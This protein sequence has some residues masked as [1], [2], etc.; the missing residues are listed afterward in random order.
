MGV[1]V[2][3]LLNRK[4]KGSGA[5]G[6]KSHRTGALC[7]AWIQAWASQVPGKSWV[8]Y[9]LSPCLHFFICTGDRK[10]PD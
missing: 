10:M 4:G 6:R 7:S 9:L 2:C 1:S 8:N 3:W 5:R